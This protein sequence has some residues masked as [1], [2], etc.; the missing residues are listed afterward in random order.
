MSGFSERALC[1]GTTTS[2]EYWTVRHG[3]HLEPA[4]YRTRGAALDAI[5]HLKATG[6]PGPYSVR[7]HMTTEYSGPDEPVEEHLTTR[8]LM[9]AENA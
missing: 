3:K 8:S 5:R 1:A 6:T 4:S 7:Y 2:W 9:A